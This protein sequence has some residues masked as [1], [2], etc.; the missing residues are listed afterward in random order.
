M[1]AHAASRCFDYRNTDV[2]KCDIAV[3]VTDCDIG[4]K[5]TFC[6]LALRLPAIS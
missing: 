5:V 4:G 2:A 3:D 6:D 1:A